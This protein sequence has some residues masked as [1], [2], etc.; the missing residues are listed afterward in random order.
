MQNN[1]LV[2]QPDRK[3]FDFQFA[4]VWKYRELLYFLSMARYQSP[5]QTDCPGSDLDRAATL[6]EHVGV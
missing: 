3:L 5:L 4:K 2:I 6:A 1:Q